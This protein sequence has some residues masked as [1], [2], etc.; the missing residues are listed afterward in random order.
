AC[1]FEGE[2][3]KVIPDVG[4]NV[5]FVT[6]QFTRV[7]RT[8]KI[9]AL[10]PDPKSLSILQATHGSNPRVRIFPIAAADRDGEV[11]LVQRRVSCN[12]S[13]LQTAFQV[14]GEA[15]TTIKVKASTLDRFCAEHAI[16]HIDLLKIDT[17]GA[18]LLVLKGAK[19]M[20][21][22]DAIDVVMTEVL[23]VPT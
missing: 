4:A 20:L 22:K 11:D 10:E 21:E 9:Y 3:P 15:K 5:G 13:L 2:D 16:A 14:N 8:A 23:F 12:S 19:E 17:E 1:L 6:W 18:D 7:F